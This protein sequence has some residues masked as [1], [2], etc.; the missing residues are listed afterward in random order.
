[1]RARVCGTAE[2]PRLFVFRSNRH[3]VAQI[4]DDGK[5]KTLLTATDEGIKIEKSAA[6]K[7]A[8][9]QKTG[10]KKSPVEKELAGKRALAFEVGK[11]IAKKAKELKIDEV[12]F[13]R[14][15]YLYHG[16]VKSLAD[17]ARTGGLKF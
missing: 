7:P 10:E 14:G 5:N 8:P 13:D 9:D 3:I 1:M 16:R 11:Q 17:G 6:L 15:G 2:K 12:V 4:I